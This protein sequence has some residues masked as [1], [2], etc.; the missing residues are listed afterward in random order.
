M[1][2]I[3]SNGFTDLSGVKVEARPS[4]FLNRG[5]IGEAQNQFGITALPGGRAL[6]GRI[7]LFSTTTVQTDIRIDSFVAGLSQLTNRSLGLAII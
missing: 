6:M 3:L 7:R 1:E 5:L 2:L 4:P